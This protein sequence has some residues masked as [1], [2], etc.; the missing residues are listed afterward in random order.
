MEQMMPNVSSR[1]HPMH[2]SGAIPLNIGHAHAA[3]SHSS[4]NNNNNSDNNNNNNRN[5]NDGD[6]IKS[7]L[8]TNFADQ[9]T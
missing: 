1:N 2:G 4:N 6:T 7:E 3:N 8:E 5:I 9:M